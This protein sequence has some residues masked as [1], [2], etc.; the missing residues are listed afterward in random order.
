MNSGV[1]FAVGVAGDGLNGGVLVGGQERSKLVRVDAVILDRVVEQRDR[2]RGLADGGGHSAQV[3]DVR[4]ALLVDL[5]VVDAL[6][7]AFEFGDPIVA[8]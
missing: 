4:R 1:G 8:H 3:Q 6:C 2:F 5:A 7:D